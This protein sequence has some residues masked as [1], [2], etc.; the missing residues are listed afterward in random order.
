M[1]DKV[2]P[3]QRNPAHV[4]LITDQQNNSP[5]GMVQPKA[6]CLSPNLTSQGF[7]FISLYLSLPLPLFH[8]LISTLVLF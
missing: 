5:C 8:I 2:A 7:E 4:S 6:T 1:A 3:I